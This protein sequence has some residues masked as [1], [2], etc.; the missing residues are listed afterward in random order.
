MFFSDSLKVLSRIP[1]ERKLYVIAR[2]DIVVYNR[3]EEK[4]HMWIFPS[5][6]V[7]GRILAEASKKGKRVPA[8]YNLIFL[9]VW[10][11]E[12]PQVKQ[13]YELAKCYEVHEEGIEHEC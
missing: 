7:F 2:D 13:F 3:K 6:E 11:L 10:V 5:E 12:K 9:Y 8:L 1:E 4:T